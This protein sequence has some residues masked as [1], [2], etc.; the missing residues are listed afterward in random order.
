MLQVDTTMLREEDRSPRPVEIA[1]FTPWLPDQRS[2]SLP[3][4]REPS[5]ETPGP[6]RVCSF[7]KRTYALWFFLRCKQAPPTPEFGI[8]L[9]LCRVCEEARQEAMSRAESSMESLN[10]SQ[11]PFSFMAQSWEM[12]RS[13]VQRQKVLLRKWGRWLPNPLV[14]YYDVY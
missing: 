10:V 1:H 13:P 11:P 6:Q 14:N 4:G 5:R 9:S 3:L 8:P 7:L 12:H 2:W